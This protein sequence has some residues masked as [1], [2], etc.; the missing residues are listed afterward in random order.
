VTP[1]DFGKSLRKSHSAEDMPF[2]EE[3]YRKAFPGFLGM[4]NHRADGPHQRA[5]ID[6]S[7]ILPNSKQVLIDE[8]VRF[9]NE[10]TGIVYDDVALEYISD[11]HRGELGWVCKPLMCDYIAYAIAPLGR[12]YLL[13]VIQLQQAW[14]KNKLLWMT[15]KTIRADNEYCGRKWRTL[16]KPVAVAELFAAIGSCLRAEFTPI[17]DEPLEEF[18]PPTPPQHLSQRMF[19]DWEK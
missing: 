6:R 17:E 15:Y 7:I 2:W 13:P 9:R 12:C 16:S 5:G 4:F 19:P 10:K 1:H 18:I 11:E 3:V 14:E 8:K